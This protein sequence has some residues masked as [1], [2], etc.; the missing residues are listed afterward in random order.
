MKILSFL[1]FFELELSRGDSYTGAPPCALQRHN[2][3]KGKF[4][5][6]LSIHSLLSTVSIR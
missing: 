2:S 1:T 3:H 6:L 5:N 4:V